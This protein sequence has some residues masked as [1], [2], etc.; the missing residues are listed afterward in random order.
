MERYEAKDAER[1]AMRVL[2]VED[3]REI[4]E[5]IGRRLG[6]SGFVAD[7]VTSC[8]ETM[9]ALESHRYSL[10]LLDRRLPDGDGMTLL[11]DIRRMQPGIRILMLTVCNATDDKIGG[12]EAGADDYMTKP[13]D[14]DELVA[15]MRAIL[16][17][18][19]G[20]LLPLITIGALS[21]DPNL[22][23]AL[24]ADQPVKMPRQEL[25]L[26]EILMRNVDRMVWRQTLIEEIYGITKD[27]QPPAVNLLIMRLR[28]R[29]NE[30]H[31][32]VEIHAARGIGYMLS[33]SG[34]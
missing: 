5:L 13:F 30:L 27:V 31:A 20:D 8:D 18:P 21:F 34:T 10:V 3:E 11:P 6:R 7:H 4:A 23:N 17:R 33:K 1:M 25:M 12:L 16:R 19:G 14:S 15:R 24:I 32:G 2:M 26:L 28:R 29:L 22:R 9:A